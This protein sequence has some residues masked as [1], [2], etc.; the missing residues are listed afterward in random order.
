M[1]MTMKRDQSLMLQCSAC[2]IPALFTF[3]HLASPCLHYFVVIALATFSETE[4]STH[5]YLQTFWRG[6][7]AIVLRL[8]CYYSKWLSSLI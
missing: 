2:V 8:L 5:V 4:S 7:S 1:T 3:E 6:H